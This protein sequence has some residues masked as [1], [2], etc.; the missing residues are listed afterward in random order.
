[1]SAVVSNNIARQPSLNGVIGNQVKQEQPGTPC[2]E[3][4]AKRDMIIG[5]SDLQVLDCFCR[6]QYNS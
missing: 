4:R 1:M 5:N 3:I 2:L 6:R